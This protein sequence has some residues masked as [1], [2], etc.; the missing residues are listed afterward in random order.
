VKLITERIEDMIDLTALTTIISESYVASYQ[1]SSLKVRRR[2][3]RLITIL[4]KAEKLTMDETQQTIYSSALKT[5]AQDSLDQAVALQQH[6]WDLPSM[7]LV[8]R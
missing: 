5:P 2:Y 6:R 4:K 8:R 3:R 7:S 1:G